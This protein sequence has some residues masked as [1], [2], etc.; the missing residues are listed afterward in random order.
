MEA[1]KTIWTV[2]DQPP[3][4]S[5]D[6]RKFAV[7]VRLIQLLQNEQ[8]GNGPNLAA[9]PGVT[10][11]PVT[12]EGVSGVSVPFPPQA[13]E[14]EAQA[15]NQAPAQ[16]Q[17]VPPRA[18]TSAAPPSPSGGPPPAAASLAL[19][20]QSPYSLSPTEQARY[21]SLFPQYE[22]DGFVQGKTAFDLFSK[23]GV[24]QEQLAAIWR[25]VDQPVD[26]R[27][28]KLEFAIAMH[29]IVCVSQKNMP[30]P[31]SLP[32]ALKQL[33]SQQPQHPQAPEPQAPQPA[34]EQQPPAEQQ[35]PPPTVGQQQSLPP[36]QL[37]Q[38]PVMNHAPTGNA[39]S[40]GASVMSALS[41]PP[42]L[43]PPGAGTVSISDAFEG[44][45]GSTTVGGVDSY[46]ASAPPIATSTSSYD[47]ES[48]AP[49]PVHNEAPPVQTVVSPPVQTVVQPPPTQERS[50][51]PSIGLPSVA[52]TDQ[53]ASG[54]RDE[55]DKLKAV[56]QTLK[57]ENIALKASMGS[58]AGDE[59][60][61]QRELS[62]TVSEIEE[63]SA[64]LT[65]LRAQVLS[66]KS[67]LLEATSELKAAKQQ[68]G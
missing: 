3:T 46:L 66:S 30:C 43:P 26:N 54:H 52:S 18:P 33:K 38:P 50:V 27:L 42:P 23:S 2:A 58:L 34:P 40:S 56:V 57:A 31:P 21:E 8:K 16:Q 39:M 49:P 15:P 7:A 55:L 61:V 53:P 48:N 59:E 24:P 60:D 19:T 36:P 35:I 32:L 20:P 45:E 41:A 6:K 67:R 14:P 63:L 44:L 1:L 5:L 62:A 47:N 4:Q 37:E 68:K 10:L 25:M 29:L 64:E 9:P 22:Q 13:A 28:D 17:Q 11:R 51:E 65:T 12:F